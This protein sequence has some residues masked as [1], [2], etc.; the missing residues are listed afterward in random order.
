MAEQDEQYEQDDFDMFFG[1]DDDEEEQVEETP[2]PEETPQP[3]ADGSQKF[4]EL[5]NQVKGDQVFTAYTQLRA[6]GFSEADAVK[7]MYNYMKE[8]GVF[9][10]QPP[11][12]QTFET[13]IKNEINALKKELDEYKRKESIREVSSRNAG[14]AFNVLSKYGLDAT[15]ENA[16]KY[17]K[18]LLEMYPKWD[19][20]QELSDAQVKNIVHLAFA[21]D[22]NAKRK[23]NMDA[24]R[25]DGVPK[26]LQ[27]MSNG[28]LTLRD[29]KHNLRKPQVEPKVS[30]SDERI[31]NILA[32]LG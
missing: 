22:M 1:G 27:G 30:T 5:A 17:N 7:Y 25:Q 21:K 11:V 29:V 31:K 23:A 32:Q 15:D 28:G 20:T 18:T 2:A 24:S 26:I 3:A 9:Q 14:R 10:E 16:S 8:K 6:E 19:G 4:L 12:E 13:N